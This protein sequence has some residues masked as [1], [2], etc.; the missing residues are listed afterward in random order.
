[1]ADSKN[2]KKPAASVKDK[3]K[4]RLGLGGI[5]LSIVALVL[6]WGVSGYNGLVSSRESVSTSFANVQTQYQRRADLIPNLV[7]TVQGAADFEQETLLQVVEARSKAT[8]INI[9][10]STATPEQ[11]AEY[12]NAQNELSG[13]LG[14]LLVVVES[15]P[16]LT[17]TQAFRDLQVQLEG[18]ENRIQVSRSDYNNVLKGYNTKVQKFP[19]SILAGMFGFDQRPYFDAVDGADTAPKVEF[20]Q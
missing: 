1:M 8:S 19:K 7:S 10:P 13:S 3:V 5:I 12:Q 18:T 17:A 6:I 11:L 14:R 16:Q 4:G 9:D 2:M 20:N 15:Y